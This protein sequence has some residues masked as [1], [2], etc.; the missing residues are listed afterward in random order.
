M[1]LTAKND[2]IGQILVL[3]GHTFHFVGFVLLQLICIL[4]VTFDSIKHP[5]LP[6]PP[7]PYKKDPLTTLL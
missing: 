5:F 7:H 3:A 6:T 2:Q 1:E 4:L